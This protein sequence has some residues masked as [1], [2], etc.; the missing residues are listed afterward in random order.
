MLPLRAV[1]RGLLDHFAAFDLDGNGYLSLMEAQAGVPEMAVT[2]FVAL[3]TSRD[4]LLWPDELR[5]YLSPS[6]TSGCSADGRNG[7]SPWGDLL[8]LVLALAVLIAVAR[9]GEPRVVVPASAR[10]SRDVTAGR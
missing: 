8:L 4:G 1:A 10:R 9:R 7:D 3:D 2:Q 6:K 5:A